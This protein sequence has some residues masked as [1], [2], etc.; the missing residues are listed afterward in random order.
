MFNHLGK[1]FC[2]EWGGNKHANSFTIEVHLVKGFLT[3]FTQKFRNLLVLAK[4]V[5]FAPI[6]FVHKAS[7][8]GQ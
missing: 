6:I 3:H 5:F 1:L 4:F 8:N 7:A 2:I